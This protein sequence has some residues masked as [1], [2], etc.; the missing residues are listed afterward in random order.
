M[1]LAVA[2][3][4]APVGLYAQAALDQVVS[5]SV[6][7]VSLSEALLRLKRHSGVPLAWRGDQVPPAR[8][9]SVNVRDVPLREVLR[10]LLQG[11]W[12]T[13]RVTGSGTVV[14]VVDPRDA[15][16]GH[17]TGVQLLDQ[18]VVTGSAVEPAAGREQPTAISVITARDIEA[19]PHYRLSDALR[20]FLPGLVLWDHGG[21]GPPPVVAGVRGVASFTSR[22]AK[23]YIDGVEVASPELFTLLDLRGVS[24]IE[25]IHGPQGAALY[26]H[27]AI[28]GVIQI[29]THK[30]VLGTAH[31][32][33]TVELRGGG[34]ARQADG[35][36]LWREA[37]GAVE[38][39]TP[40]V[41]AH[42][43]GSWSQ[44]GSS[45][46]LAT[47]RRGQVAG[48]WQASRLQL[49]W[50]ARVAEHDGVLERI[51][52]SGTLGTVRRSEPLHERGASVRLLHNAAAH[53]SHAVTVGAHRIAGSREPSRSAILPPTLPLGATNETASRYSVRWAGTL[54]RNSIAM[55]VGAE[56]SRRDLM[57]TARPPDIMAD[58]ST[59]YN[60]SLDTRGGFA[61][62]R[63]RQGAFVM[64]AG[65]RADRISSLGAEARTPWAS[66]AGVTWSAPIGLNTLRLRGAWGRALRPPEPGMSA[67]LI[68]GSIAQQANPL[69]AAEQQS[70]YEL[71]AEWHTA[72][73]HWL[74]FT[75]FDQRAAS[76]LQQVDLRRTVDSRRVYQFQN[77]GAITNRGI[78]I[79]GG[80]Q[81][82]DVSA[83]ARLNLVRSR[84]AELS[85][86]YTGE[87]EPGD[88]PL[89]VPASTASVAIRYD[90]GPWR[91]EGGATW[92][93]PW[94]GYDWRLIQRVEAGQSPLRDR[95]REYW[96]DYE[97]VLRP[98]VGASAQ[99]TSALTLLARAEWPTSADAYLRDNLT[100]S[101]GRS[102]S[103]G[104]R[105]SR[106]AAPTP[107]A[108]PDPLRR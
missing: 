67:A 33:P 79:D 93:G 27:E 31:V 49:Q 99:L 69:L 26:G 4:S 97:G 36:S 107:P 56:A 30:G 35:T 88:A 106:H 5:L 57:R 55:T 53:F 20:A 47:V 94:T 58:L 13:P 51:T 54:E 62:L 96:L 50:S 46:P 15:T 29:E 64:T 18:L 45:N 52:A 77:V 102:F 12:L 98:F 101:P 71:G 78:E 16:D 7:D 42:A 91:V 25:M 72:A 82:Q 61:Q 70:G 39:G 48:R 103:I 43:V 14:L 60:E 28:A 59:L 1:L 104:L 108:A 65:A 6:R 95:A 10:D 22:A 32:A 83:A 80:V 63:V 92:I 66:T 105:L 86:T 38:A 81:L 23:V 9:V 11:T 40:Q 85:P 74:R 73:G 41:A 84:V 90:R 89:E 87:F 34:L 75:W 68:A 21:A 2:L 76:L 37:A 24:Q 8:R 44:I 100:P 17:A 3:L 19:A